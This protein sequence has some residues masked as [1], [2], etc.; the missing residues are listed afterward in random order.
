MISLQVKAT[1]HERRAP[2]CGKDR[3]FGWWPIQASFAWVGRVAQSWRSSNSGV[4]ADLALRSGSRATTTATCE[5]QMSSEKL[6][7]IHRNPVKRGLC[8]SPE[9]WPWSSFRHYWNGAAVG[10]EIESE[11][12]VRARQVQME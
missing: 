4:V 8:A 1:Y 12:T 5:L 7:Y 9:Q 10:V 11:W 6:R 2:W 3:E